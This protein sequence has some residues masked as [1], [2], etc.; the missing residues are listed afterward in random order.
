[1]ATN[2]SAP[3]PDLNLEEQSI[4]TID[5][6]DPGAVITEVVIH[7][8]QEIQG[9]EQVLPSL[10]PL[11]VRGITQEFGPGPVTS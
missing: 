8:S 11:Y 1:M 5:T 7:V 4:L 6:G 9:L 3:L 10:L 2:V